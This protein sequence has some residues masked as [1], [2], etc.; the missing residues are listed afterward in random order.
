LDLYIKILNFIEFHYYSFSMKLIF[1]K[2]DPTKKIIMLY[3]IPDQNISSEIQT[4][5]E[6]FYDKYR[7][8]NPEER[9]DHYDIGPYLSYIFT[10]KSAWYPEEEEI[11]MLTLYFEEHENTHFFRPIM[12]QTITNLKE[13]PNL[14]KILYVNTPHAD[15]E[16]FKIFGKIIRIL[17]DCFFEASKLHSTYNLGLS[18]VLLLGDKGSGK[19]SIV[20]YLIHGKFVPQPSPTLTPR[21]F[22]LIY[23]KVDFRVLDICCEEHLKE[24]FEDHPLEPGKL[25]QA[26]VYVIDATQNEEDLQNSVEDFNEW[27][28]FLS[29]EYPKSIYNKLPFLI[30]FNK[31]DLTPDFDF[32][33]YKKLFSPK[34]FE[35]NTQY[36]MS[37]VKTGEGLNQNFSWVVNHIKVTERY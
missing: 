35:L 20:D 10:V 11:L 30:L 24:V 34:D 1:S 33:R 7:E 9:L 37:S 15:N 2:F 28:K 29:K 25:P 16:S 21:I 5:L 27:T 36:T 6:K 13:I 32:E 3:S 18:E 4:N 31:S 22:R 26:F 12:E 19:T 8:E 23:D 14:T 17:T